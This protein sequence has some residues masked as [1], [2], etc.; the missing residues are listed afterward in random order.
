MS[1]LGLA[2]FPFFSFNFNFFILKVIII[3]F[4]GLLVVVR[5]KRHLGD[6]GGD[7]PATDLEEERSADLEVGLV[8]VGHRDVLAQDGA[9]AA[10]ADS[11][12]LLA[13]LVV[14][15]GALTSRCTARDEAN[16]LPRHTVLDLVEDRTSANEPTSLTSP[17]G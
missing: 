6:L 7:H 8:D 3:I 17:F 12:D 16:T 14:D 9:G 10:A 11:A 13:L 5:D 2:F 4:K 1:Y 15:S